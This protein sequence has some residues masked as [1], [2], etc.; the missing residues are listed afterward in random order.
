[1]RANSDSGNVRLEL[2]GSRRRAWAHTDSGNVEVVAADARIVD[3]K[4]DSGTIT[5]GSL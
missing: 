1:M 3:A 2:V 4:T 5:L